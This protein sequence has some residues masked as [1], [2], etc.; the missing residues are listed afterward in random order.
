MKVTLAEVLESAARPSAELVTCIVAVPFVMLPLGAALY[1]F[2][3]ASYWLD[4]TV[5][6]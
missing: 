3:S 1:A 2:S 5:T 4:C 6:V